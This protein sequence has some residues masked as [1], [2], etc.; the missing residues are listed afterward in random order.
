MIRSLAL[1]SAAPAVLALAAAA[2]LTLTAA[3]AAHAVGE[4]SKC[5]V[6]WSNFDAKVGKNAWNY[7]T[8][9]STG[10]SSRGYLY[11][12]DK[13]KVLCSKGSWDYSELTQRSNSGIA[14]GTRGWVRED[15]LVS[16]AG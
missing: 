16:L 5:S 8:G 3:P 14:K 11:R 10:Y 12:G 2:T 7:R 6:N 9:P 1:R 13:L 15:G 4:S